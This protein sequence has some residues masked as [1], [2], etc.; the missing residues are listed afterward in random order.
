MNQEDEVKNAA[1]NEIE[2]INKEAE[3]NEHVLKLH[4]IFYWLEPETP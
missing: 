2:K 3:S 1:I 4:K